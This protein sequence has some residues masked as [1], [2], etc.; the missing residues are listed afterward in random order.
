MFGQ[1]VDM[2]E[3]HDGFQS[4]FLEDIFYHIDVSTHTG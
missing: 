3:A 4:R 1:I 2:N